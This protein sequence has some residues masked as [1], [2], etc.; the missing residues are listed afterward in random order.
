GST[1][2]SGTGKVTLSNNAGNAVISNGVAATL[3]NAGDTISGAGTIGDSYLTLFN[4]G[5]INANQTKALVINTGGN[6]ITN[7]RTLE[8]TS[9]GGL[10]IDSDVSNSRT[11]EALGSNTH[12]VID[13]VI[14]NTATGVILASGSGAQVDLDGATILGGTLET[15]GTNAFIETVSGSTNVLDGGTISS[16]STV[17]INNGT[18]LALDDTITNFGTLLVNGGTLN[19]NGVVNGG[20]VE[21]EGKGKVT[22]AQANSENVTFQ[23]KSTGELVLDS[24]SYAGK[25]SGF[26]AQTSQ[27]IDLSD[28]DFAAGARIVSYVPNSKNTGGVL[29]VT[30]GTNTMQLQMA[31]TY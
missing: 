6:T 4:Q 25:I 21:I 10:D 13:S 9:T 31:G 29:T 28:I 30:D 18:T 12:V 16:G 23:A 3:T 15:S 19:I 24:T 8:A 2:L 7:S 22:I 1:T 27:S 14:T 11:I 5:T 20:L 26:G 17:E